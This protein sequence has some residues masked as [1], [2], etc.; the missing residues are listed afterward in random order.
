M[1]KFFKRTLVCA[2]VASAATVG[3][4]NAAVQVVG[5]AVQFYGQ[6]AGALIVSDHAKAGKE[7]TVIADIESR[8]GFRGVV[9]FED[10][11]PNFVWQMEGGNANNGTNSGGLGVRD[12][13]LGLDWD[14]FG[15]VKFGRQLVAAYN[16]VD[17]HTNPGTGYVFDGWVDGALDLGVGWEGRADHVIR[18]D[19][20]NWNGFTLQASL[21]GMSGSTD[22]KTISF[23]GAYQNDNMLLHAGYYDRGETE[24]ADALKVDGS[25][26]W[27]AGAYFFL[28][29]FTI[30]AAVRD[31]SADYADG[32][33]NGQMSYSGAIQYTINENWFVKAGYAA[34]AKSDQAKDAG[35][36]DS[37][38][39][40]TAR[41]AFLQPSFIIYG[42]IRDYDMNGDSKE[43]DKTDFM[44][45]IEYYF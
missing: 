13:Y 37:D 43:T 44:L 3:S 41:V 9:E 12:T 42:D 23:A 22:A 4:A 6:A 27:I 32:T 24:E 25:N 14:G 31:M 34:Q 29:D 5:D 2:A 17:G 15:S 39:A 30:N 35:I 40:V 1:D 45:G 19:S 26:Y 28:G 18:Y 8:V 21:S 10:L 11:E 36:D 33:D 7:N 16:L 38:S 20:A